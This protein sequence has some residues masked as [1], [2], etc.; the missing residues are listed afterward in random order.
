MNRPEIII[1]ILR[2]LD[3]KITGPFMG[4]ASVRA[5]S[6]EY[7][8]I[9][10]EYRADAW[11]YGTVTTKEFTGGRRPQLEETG[12]PVPGGDFAAV[13][14]AGLYYVSVDTLGE[15]G[16][17]SG[18]FR[19]PGRPDAHVI[20]ILTERT[21]AAYRRYLRRRGV[22]YIL[23]GK[24]ALDCLEA[25]EKVYALIGIRTMLVCGGGTVNWTFLQ[26]GM[27][28]EISIVLAPAADGNRESVTVF[29]QMPGLP[30]DPFAE[31]EL[32]DVERL[33]DSGLHLVYAPVGRE[34]KAGGR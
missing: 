33:K 23:A 4:A 30:S 9:R 18:T 20:E 3:G 21:P 27:A 26:Q 14:D 12:D 15:I 13:P 31:F 1:H 22:S 19:M 28:D 7:A 16:W 10:S 29:E 2:A 8:R 5:A 24:D 34:R 17:E 6:G 25:C 32:K 11:L